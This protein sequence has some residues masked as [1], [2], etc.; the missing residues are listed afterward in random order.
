MAALGHEKICRLDVA[1]NDSAF[2]R[3]VKR[4]GDLDGEGQDRLDLHRLFGNA[5][6]QGHAIQKLH[7][8]EGF[9]MLVVNFVNGADVGMV[10]RGG[11][12]RLALEAA[13]S[14]RIFGNFIGQEL[15]GDKAAKFNVFGF[16]D[17]THPAAA[18]H[19]ND[20]VMRD[21][22]ADHA[23][24]VYPWPIILGGRTAASQC[25][26]GRGDVKLPV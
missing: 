16:I 19:F 7:G 1:V 6:L 15:E 26:A 25:V 11:S 20:A 17:D 5:V 9:A 21:G 24:T 4:V 14:L 12:F 13:E 18:E 23:G 22:L 3:R 2:M 10:Q 8:D